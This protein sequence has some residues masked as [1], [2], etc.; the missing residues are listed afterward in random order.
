MAAIDHQISRLDEFV[1]VVKDRLRA[2]SSKGDWRE[3]K[4]YHPGGVDEPVNPGYALKRL[5]EELR[6]LRLAVERGQAAEEVA[7]EAADVAAFAL[8]VS[9]LYSLDPAWELSDH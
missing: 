3:R 4:V 6:E 8:I 2:C 5:G 1:T 9:D 7:R